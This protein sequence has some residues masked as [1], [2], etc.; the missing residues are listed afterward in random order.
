[1]KN[2]KLIGAA[3]ALTLSSTGFAA[4]GMECCKDEATCCCKKEGDKPGCCDKMKKDM[5]ASDHSG[6]DMPDA[7]KN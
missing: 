4:E 3:L 2:L 7:P 6:H 5:P 1:M